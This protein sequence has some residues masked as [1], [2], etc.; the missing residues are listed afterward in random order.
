[1]TGIS[2]L[3]DGYIVP[4]LGTLFGL[5]ITPLGT[6]I[7]YILTKKIN[8]DRIKTALDILDDTTR[9]VVLNLNQDYVPKLRNNDGVLSE[10]NKKSIK[11]KAFFMIKSQIKSET[12][13]FLAKNGYDVEGRIYILIESQVYKAKLEAGIEL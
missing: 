3:F 1:M 5:V 10:E 7:G 8:E 9:S 6:Y 12:L 2:A 11:E 13:D 4:A